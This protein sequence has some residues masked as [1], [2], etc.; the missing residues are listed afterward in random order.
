MIEF[1]APQRLVIDTFS[2]VNEI[3]RVLKL[4]YDDPGYTI[5][6]LANLIG[7]SRK[8]VSNIIKKLKEQEII[9]RVGNNKKGYWKI[10]E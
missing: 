5:T 3:N 10:K 9:E 7:I 1:I 4:L 8:S 2:K 6:E